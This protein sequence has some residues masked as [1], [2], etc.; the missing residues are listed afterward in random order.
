MLFDKISFTAHKLI[1]E[2]P[3]LAIRIVLENIYPP[4]GVSSSRQNVKIVELRS[5]INA[6]QSSVIQKSIGLVGIQVLLKAHAI[7]QS[8]RKLPLKVSVQTN[9]QYKF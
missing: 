7:I 4:A 9:V 8:F 5:L 1:W 2:F 3:A 6:L